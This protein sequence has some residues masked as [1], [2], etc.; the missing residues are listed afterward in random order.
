MDHKPVGTC[1]V[2]VQRP[3][4]PRESARTAG[5]GAA[6]A[7]GLGGAST[8]AMPRHRSLTASSAAVSSSSASSTV[9]GPMDRKERNRQAAAASRKR[10]AAQLEGLEVSFQVGLSARAAWRRPQLRGRQRWCR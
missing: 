7:L 2:L 6:C 8:A 4:V 5:F 10:K 1:I 9:G 3:S